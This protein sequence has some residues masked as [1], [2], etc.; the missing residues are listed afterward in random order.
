MGLKYF[1]SGARAPQPPKASVSTDLL[2]ELECRACPLNKAR[3]DTP[4][5]QPSGSVKPLIYV[6]GEAPS[7]SDDEEGRQ[8]IGAVGSFIRPF[9]PEGSARQL[10]GTTLQDV[11]RAAVS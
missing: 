11:G 2:H 5:M 6:M 8:F 1:A 4:K 7:Q 10:G 9:I 3:I